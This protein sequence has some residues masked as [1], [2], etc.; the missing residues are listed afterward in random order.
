MRNGSARLIVLV[1][2]V[3]V[4]IVI[5]TKGLS[6]ASS[7]SPPDDGGNTTAPSTTSA[8]PT[9]TK[10]SDGGPTDG[11]LPSPQQQGV[12]L[13]IYNATTTDGLAG[14]AE[15]DLKKEGYVVAETGNFPQAVRTLIY[16]RNGDQGKADAQHLRENFIPEAD[17][18]KKLPQGLPS[19]SAIPK[20]AEIV[21][22]LGNNYAANHPVSG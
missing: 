4:G 18:P 9:T 22:V 2:A 17:A 16:Y 10:S 20:D 8:S 13:A 3:V 21:V 11:G 15:A 5:L 19:D 12:V 14:A 6:G 1:A 7:P